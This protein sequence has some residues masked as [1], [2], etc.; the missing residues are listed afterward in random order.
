MAS[1]IMS[2]RAAARETVQCLHEAKELNETF[3]PMMSTESDGD[4][5]VCEEKKTSLAGTER[6]SRLYRNEVS[7]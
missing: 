5:D 1:K 2:Q 3:R 7:V 4:E 6:K